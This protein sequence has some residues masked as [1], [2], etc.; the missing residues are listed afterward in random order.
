MSTPVTGLEMLCRS[1]GLSV[2]C[3]RLLVTLLLLSLQYRGDTVMGVSLLVSPPFNL[4]TSEDA[5][6]ARTKI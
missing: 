6:A 5:P 3:S 1:P 4:C 2:R